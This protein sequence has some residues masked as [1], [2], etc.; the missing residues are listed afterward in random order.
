[1]R[2]PMLLLTALLALAA[3]AANATTA[4]SACDPSHGWSGAAEGEPPVL[5]LRVEADTVPIWIGGTGRLA[6]A[7]ARSRSP[8]R[9][10][11]WPSPRTACT[12]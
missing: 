10:S 7:C 9:P 1:M 11:A 5:R 2:Q 8:G 3:L 4:Q 12:P 6:P